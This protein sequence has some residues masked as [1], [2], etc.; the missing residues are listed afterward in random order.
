MFFDFWIV[1]SPVAD[2]ANGP[3]SPGQSRIPGHPW[4]A[5]V[6]D[7][8]Q[9]H[10]SWMGYGSQCNCQGNLE[11]FVW[12]LQLD[13]IVGNFLPQRFKAT[14]VLVL[15]PCWC[16]VASTGEGFQRDGRGHN[17][18]V[19][20]L[21]LALESWWRG[22]VWRSAAQCARRKSQNQIWKIPEINA[23]PY[24]LQEVAGSKSWPLGELILW[25]GD[26]CG[27]RGGRAGSAM[28]ESHVSPTFL[29]FPRGRGDGWGDCFF[30]LWFHL[31]TFFSFF[32]F[33]LFGCW[34]E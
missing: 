4:M 16:T 15:L 2:S 3:P 26:G 25:G 11:A 22:C 18:P 14:V 32:L 24:I 23:T 20:L 34:C 7:W 31:S 21:G 10:P 13:R 8:P 1:A 17:I 27:G 29:S 30:P 12:A 6:R 19:W 33:L 9:T 5:W 28:R